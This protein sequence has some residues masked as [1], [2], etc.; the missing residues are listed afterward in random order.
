[1]IVYPLTRWPIEALWSDEPAVFAGVTWSQNINV[2]LLV[3]GLA[4]QL[5]LRMRFQCALRDSGL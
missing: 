1:M 3:G 4:L 2:A 5:C